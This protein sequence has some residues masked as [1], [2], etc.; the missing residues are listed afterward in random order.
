MEKTTIQWTYSPADYFPGEVS[1]DT[2]RASLKIHEG[3]ITATLKTP[4]E[5][6]SDQLVASVRSSVE[7]LFIARQL[8]D[9]KEYKI[10][11]YSVHNETAD[12]KRHVR[13]FLQSAAFIIT[14]G[15]AHAIVTDASGRVI[16]DSRAEQIGEVLKFAPMIASRKNDNLSEWILRRLQAAISDKN[17]EL[18]YYYD[19]LDA[20]MTKFGG[21]R[22]ACSNLS[23]EKKTWSRIGYLANKAPLLEGRHRGLHFKTIRKATEDEI[24]EARKHILEIVNSYLKFASNS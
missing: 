11:G 5:A 13:V 1:F 24:S 7:D 10:E 19:I 22:G 20:I 3:K 23:I 17:N 12:G 14:S 2:D 6:L 18:V 4:S 9:F 21:I 16:H 15:E 8:R